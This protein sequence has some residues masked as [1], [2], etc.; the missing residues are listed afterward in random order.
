[1]HYEWV[2]INASSVIIVFIITHLALIAISSDWALTHT[3]V[4]VSVVVSAVVGT[5]IAQLAA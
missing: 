4:I 3:G 5:V 1:M 2:A